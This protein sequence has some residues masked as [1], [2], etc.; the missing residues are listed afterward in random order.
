MIIRMLLAM[1][2]VM[3]IGGS[4]VSLGAPITVSA[5]DE[6]G[7]ESFLGFPAWYKGVT[8]PGEGGCKVVVKDEEDGF[9]RFIWRVA[10]NVIQAFMVALGYATAGMLMYGGFLFITSRGKP[11]EAAQARSTMQ[12]AFIGLVLSLGAVAIVSFIA[13]GLVGQ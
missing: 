8:E 11:E 12:E 13:N 10:L 2:A 1:F 7:N 9:A 3:T 4:A 6:C 5:A